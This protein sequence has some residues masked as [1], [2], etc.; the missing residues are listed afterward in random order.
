M[1]APIA[2]YISPKAEKGSPSS[3]AGRGVVAVAPIAAGEVVAVKGGH[4]VTATELDALPSQLQNSEI[5]VAEGLYLAALAE[6]EY[7]PVMLF[8]NHSCDPNVGFA[9]N[10][11]LVAMRD[12]EKG[13]ELTTDYALFDTP[14]AE[15]E[16]RCGTSACRGTIRG[17]DW[18]LPDLQSRYA[19]Y[20]STYVQRRIDATRSASGVEPL[21]DFVQSDLFPFEGEMRLK[22]LAAAV[23]PEPP[24]S[25]EDPADCGSCNADD[26]HC[27]WSDERWRLTVIRRMACPIAMILSPRAHYDSPDLPED[28]AA[29]LGVLLI[30]IERAVLA[31]GGIGRVHFSKWCDGGAHLHWW[32]LARPEGALQQRG[33][34][35]VLWAQSLPLPPEDEVDRRAAAIA[36]Q[37][38]SMAPLR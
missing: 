24:R 11:V 30:R 6:E 12:V 36:E 5:Q 2:S 23:V 26:S 13:E 16:C 7:E 1:S 22:P 17:S 21:P 37:L 28:L 14:D 4:I 3:I 8:L 20:F 38:N 32:I 9:G 29:E 15:M 18:E 35:L 25:G 10:V 27:L 33:S 19:G 31:T 34:Y